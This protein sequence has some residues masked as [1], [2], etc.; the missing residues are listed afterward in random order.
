[1]ERGAPVQ[2]APFRLLRTSVVG[3]TILGL[4]AGAHLLAGGSLPGAPI[5]AAIL[6]LHIMVA[7]FAT[8]FRLSLPAMTALLGAGQVVLHHAFTALSH[9]M[10][11]AAGPGMGQA[12]HHLGGHAAAHT[13]AHM[14]QLLAQAAPLAVNTG[15]A[16]AHTPLSGAMLAAHVAASLLTA[17]VLAHGENA[18]WALA[19]WLRPLC[20]SAA[21]VRILPAQQPALALLPSP[22]P[23]LPW[24]NAPP[25]TRRGPPQ[26]RTHF[27]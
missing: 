11:M 16:V 21:V 19:G 20:R 10:P 2:H 15:E 12:A 3:T 6:A 26:L 9:T 7:T 17:A 5:M 14:A 23:H 18:L 24:R 25:D 1:M 4:A 22:L 8:T 13:D 27:S